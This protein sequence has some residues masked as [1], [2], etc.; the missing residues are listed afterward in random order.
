MGP[1][2]TETDVE[3]HWIR[4]A[5]TRDEDTADRW[6]DAVEAAGLSVEVHIEDARDALPGTTA[7]PDLVL[8]AGF[9]YGLW[10][11]PADRESALR[12]LID[13][14][15]D[16][17]HGS[18]DAPAPPARTIVRGALLAVAAAAVVVVARMVLS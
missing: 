14:G 13:V 1:A 9:A 3:R 11:A 2:A 8:G 15:W 17:R 10:I 16:G 18:V 12:A 7:I 5:A 6:R 4:V